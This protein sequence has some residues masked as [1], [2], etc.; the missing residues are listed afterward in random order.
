MIEDVL[1]LALL[2]GATAASGLF[3][4]GRVTDSE[5]PLSGD[6]PDERGLRWFDVRL[7]AAEPPL[8]SPRRPRRVPRSWGFS[9]AGWPADPQDGRERPKHFG[10]ATANFV[11]AAISGVDARAALEENQRGTDRAQQ[12]SESG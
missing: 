6:L 10:L 3:A 5:C 8:G 12:H 2:I 1:A 11:F 9:W 4:F 7:R